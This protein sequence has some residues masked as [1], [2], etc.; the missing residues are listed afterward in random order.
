VI[1]LGNALK[2]RNEQHFLMAREIDYWKI[3]KDAENARETIIAKKLFGRLHSMGVIEQRYKSKVLTL[4]ANT[5][6]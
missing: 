4:K 6:N 1:V 3:I 5:A 2:V